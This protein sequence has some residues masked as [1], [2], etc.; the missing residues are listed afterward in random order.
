MLL[1]ACIIARDAG[2][3]I[4]PC[5]ESLRRLAD[6]IVLI[7]TGSTDATPGIAH[8]IGARVVSQPWQDDFSHHR[9]AA[10]DL[11]RGDWV[12]VI[13]ADEALDL[14]VDAADTR[15]RLQ[16]GGLPRLLMVRHVSAYPGGDEV[17]EFLPRLFRRD[18]GFR[19][20]HP[21]HEQL[22]VS[23]EDAMLSNLVLRH[24]G[25]ASAERLRAKEERNLRIALGM[26][27]REPHA[28]HCRMRSLLA[29]GRT[30]EAGT[31][32]ERLLA[33]APAHRELACEAHIVLAAAALDSVRGGWE[34][35]PAAFWEQLS[36]AEAIDP[37]A[38][39]T[40]YLRLHAAARSYLGALA[41]AHTPSSGDFMRLGHFW[42]ATGPVTR[43]LRALTGEAIAGRAATGL[44]G[45]F[46]VRR[47]PSAERREDTPAVEPGAP[48]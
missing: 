44:H 32:A 36:A 34:D 23:G 30:A 6:E 9:N 1:T 10:L 5:L 39:D 40:R 31:A 24:Q 29:L 18:A 33:L 21:I 11:A 48:E 26:D 45:A 46:A 3:T 17:T 27:D 37:N 43:L 28:W 13:D 15:A 41:R 16:A 20:V 7:D 2:D 22:T 12:L 19:Y 4:G 14:E 42:R 35:P 25:Y 8:R 38:T 47:A